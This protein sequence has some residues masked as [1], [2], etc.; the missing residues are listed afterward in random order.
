VQAFS[1]NGTLDGVNRRLGRRQFEPKSVFP[2]PIM[3]ISGDQRFQRAVDERRNLLFRENGEGGTIFKI[4]KPLLNLP[5][6]T[7]C[8]GSNH[9]VRGVIS[10][11]ADITPLVREQR[12]N[13]TIAG[14][15][16]V[17]VVAI[18]TLLL[19]LYLQGT[20]IRPVKHIGAVCNDVT[21]GEFDSRVSV[22]NRDEIGVLGQTVNEMVQGLYERFHLTKFVSS[23][24]IQSIRNREKGAKSGRALLFS[25]IRNF[26]SFSETHDAETV[27][28]ALNTVLTA[29]TRIVHENGGEV[30]KYVGDEIVARFGGADKEE[31]AC[32]TALQIQNEIA[33]NP[34]VY[35]GLQV[36]VGINSGEVILGMVGSEDRADYTVIGDPVNVASRLCSMARRGT[37]LVSETVFDAVRERARGKGPVQL[38]LKGKEDPLNVYQLLAL[39]GRAK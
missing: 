33:R 2:E 27:V 18:L 10:I 24:T 20:L 29:E 14:A 11:A 8:H 31:Q 23:S 30:D 17:V 19:S 9:T 22:R 34:R 15:F 36:G 16:F 39:R 37:I 32:R 38:K 7:R 25:D 26:T 28:E 12:G 4:Y 13:V 3:V 1:D 35:Q 6:C 21:R 5:K